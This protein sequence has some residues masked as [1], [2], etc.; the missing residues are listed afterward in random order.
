MQIFSKSKAKPASKAMEY[1]VTG[2]KGYFNSDKTRQ[3]MKRSERAQLLKAYLTDRLGE[4]I[5]LSQ[6][7]EDMRVSDAQASRLVTY[8]ITNGEITRQGK[9]KHYTYTI[10]AVPQPKVRLNRQRR[11]GAKER[12]INYL[13][14]HQGELITQSDIATAVGITQ[15]Q[16]SSIIKELE[17]EGTIVKSTPTHAGT[18]YQVND[19]PNA[20]LEDSENRVSPD[21]DGERQMYE[22]INGLVWQFVRETRVTDVL[23]FLTWL[24][25]GGIKRG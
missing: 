17:A 18:L 13:T 8:L 11:S 16:T 21:A 22:A 1:E 6:I 2:N 9:F 20:H 7:A 12:L 15:P 14:V 25:Q 24:E 23:A 10:N 19:S 4:E 3:Y 5:S